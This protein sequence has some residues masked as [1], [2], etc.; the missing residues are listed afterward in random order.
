MIKRK[1]NKIIYIFI[2]SV[3]FVTILIK[4]LVQQY[5]I[6]NATY[7]FPV[8]VINK[9]G[10]NYEYDDVNYQILYNTVMVPMNETFIGIFGDKYTE[11]INQTI[12][13]KDTIIQINVEENKI[14]L[15]NIYTKENYQINDTVAIDIEDID[16]IKY[17]PVYLVSN[18]PKVVVKI[19]N[20]EVYNA[21]EY[22]TSIEAMN[23][24]KSKHK[25][26]IYT[27]QEKEENV[28][29]Y[30]GEQYGALWREEA[31]KRIEKYRKKE[32]KI[33]IK[34]NENLKIENAKI[35]ITQKSNSFNFGTAEDSTFYKKFDNDIFNLVVSENYNK[36]R[37][38]TESGYSS[39]DRMYN[40]ALENN[41]R[42]KGH[43]L[44]WDYIYSTELK[45]LITS[46][47]D[48]NIT[49]ESIY[50]KYN[51]NE[52]SLEEANVLIENLQI[53]FENIVYNHIKEEVSRYPEI[54]EWDVI[55]EPINF[56][57][58]KYYLYDKNLLKDKNFLTN[59]RKY[60]VKYTNNEKYSTFI[61][62]CYNLVRE[63]NN[64]SKLILNDEKIKGN[65]NTTQVNELIEL[66]RNLKTKTDNINSIGVQT[67]C[68]NNYNT[69]PQSYYNQI[70]YVLE[71]SGLNDAIISEYDNYQTEKL[72]SY[73][74]E[75][76]KTKANY[77]RDMLIMAYSNPNIS[78]FTMW[79]YY[80][81]HFCDE[82]RDIYKNT[83]YP[84]LHCT[85][86]G[87][88]TEDGYTTRLYKGSYTATVTLP[89][90]KTKEVEFNV[91]DDTSNIVEIEIDSKITNVKIKN[92]PSKINYYKNDT[93]DL[94]D[95]IIEISYDDGTTI[96][97]SMSNQNVKVSGFNATVLGK[98][99]IKL[100][101]DG[102]E[103]SFDINIEENKDAL[104]KN[105]ISSIENNNSKIKANYSY[106]SNNANI[107]KKYNIIISNL[108]SL[109]NNINSINNSKIN[110]IYKL[111]Y[112]FGL[113]IIKEYN[114]KNLNISKEELKNVIND[115]FN[116]TCDYEKL[117]QYYFNNDTMNNNDIS[118][119]VNNVIDKYNENNDIDMP[120]TIYYIN[121]VKDIYY[122]DITNEN[123]Y[124]NYLNKKRILNSIEIISY[125]LNYNIKTEAEIE[126]KNVKMVYNYDQ[127]SLT[128]RDVI[129]QIKLP[130]NKCVIENNVNNTKYTFTD[131]GTK[132]ITINIRGYKYNYEIKVT[133]IDKKSPQISRIKEGQKYQEGVTPQ[134]SDENL[135]EIKLI[136]DG[137]EVKDYKQNTKIT[138]EGVYQ[139]T[140]KDKAG[141]ETTI[142]FIIVYPE[143]ERY[144]IK[145]KK[146]T[147]IKAGTKITKLKEKLQ[148]SGNYNIKRNNKELKETE[149]VAT[150]DIVETQN[151]EK[152]VLIVKGDVNKDG[153]VNI[154]DVVK[155]RKYLLVKNNLDE[156]EKFAADTDLDGKAINIKDLI[157]IRIMLLSSNTNVT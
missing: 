34:N 98:Q 12:N 26:V 151:G 75:E 117:Y 94:T 138:Q 125:M 31:V 90:G 77:L 54:I 43:N 122:N 50:N 85:D 153:E 55:N 141:N 29:A 74:S 33:I 80:S 70:N 116:L 47:N 39:G 67:H 24:K 81:N 92:V 44:W 95:G 15:P 7:A 62:N 21:K 1:N 106:I 49:F 38:I 30:N 131:N 35:K 48:E 45:K 154:K 71:Q 132:N 51:N 58:F 63:Y 127:G 56:Q 73:T 22:L 104:I 128:N 123:N 133:N 119:S 148:I 52:I 109:K 16:G 129:V 147:N 36:W 139:L 41:L 14:T 120:L 83:V 99:K 88:T 136:K 137:E 66:I 87:T 68:N 78:E 155:M 93:I 72:N 143:D 37:V 5:K 32:E 100:E 28:T 146:V 150:G 91:S 111:E 8:S 126:S 27:D 86:Q 9:N 11:G 20:K 57:Y 69:T 145:D 149:K 110:E 96:E 157:K 130:S 144:Q 25:I 40:Y 79:V 107:L 53:E 17:I 76:K 113:E 89:N 108:N 135:S 65:Y 101:Y 140:A 156:N 142:N 84:W 114:N 42:Y 3:I 105:S 64:K 97:I 10:V 61:A 103:V 121:Q 59:T 115:I 82:E 18:L 2:I 4:N 13:Y 118:I 152:Y 102:Y 134:I 60:N 19:D 6:E 112:D 124:K 46:S 23:N